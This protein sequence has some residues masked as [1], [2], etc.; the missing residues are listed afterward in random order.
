MTR[1]VISCPPFSS[2]DSVT[3]HKARPELPSSTS[4][5][6][7]GSYAGEGGSLGVTGAPGRRAGSWTTGER[8][9]EAPA[10]HAKTC[11]KKE[12]AL[13]SPS[14]PEPSDLSFLPA[15]CPTLTGFLVKPEWQE[16]NVSAAP[17][18]SSSLVLWFA[19]FQSSSSVATLDTLAPVSPAC[20]TLDR[21]LCLPWG[22]AGVGAD[23]AAFDPIAGSWLRDHRSEPQLLAGEVQRVK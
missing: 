5:L 1:C 2:P 8:R 18:L 3:L 4:F 21:Q 6:R 9:H 20:I 17:T 11:C 10:L 16:K 15:P 14:P 23:A 7:G 19:A 13:G 22:E 12:E